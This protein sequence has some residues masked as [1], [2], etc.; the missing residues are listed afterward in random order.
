MRAQ[1]TLDFA[2]GMSVFLLAVVFVFT[3]VPGVLEPFEA[4]PQE[5]TTVADRVASQL[6]QTSMADPAEPYVLGLPCTNAFFNVTTPGDVECGFDHTAD[7]TAGDRLTDR[8]GV[9]DRQRLQVT[10]EAD[11]DGDGDV[12]ALC[13]DNDDKKVVE[14]TDSECGEAADDDRTADTDVL[15]TLGDSPSDT[16][17]V[18]T[19][20]RT[21][22]VDGYTSTVVVE[23]W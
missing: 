19:A 17:A 4:G 9:S 10:V 2:I 16:Q 22:D 6:V 21:V 13:F 5:E 15:Y 23:V 18:V 12:H 11:V 14:V 7:L 1:T 8:V 20:Q 3:F